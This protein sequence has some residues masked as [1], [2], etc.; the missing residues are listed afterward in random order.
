MG[1]RKNP[2]IE[3]L[4]RSEVRKREK[5]SNWKGGFRI[6][7]KGYRQVLMPGHHR[8]DKSGYVM[9]HILVWEM[10]TGVPV[11]PNCCIH[12]LNGDKLDNRMQNLCMMDTGSH[13]AF[14]HT[15]TKMSEST[16]RKISESSK[17]RFSDKKNNTSQKQED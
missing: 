6:T 15:G 17:K 14:H 10:K 16:K 9:E 4:N 3:Y 12:H 5:G 2:D 11:P 13:T 7:K 1:L 8:S